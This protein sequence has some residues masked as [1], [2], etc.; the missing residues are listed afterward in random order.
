MQQVF[1]TGG[2]GFVG[3]TLLA[4]LG[5]RG[6]PA[7]ALARSD[8]PANAVAALGAEVARGDLDD[9]AAMTAGMKGCDVVVHAAAHVK[10]HGTRDEFFRGNVTGTENALAAARAA[11]VTRFVH[12]GTEAVLADGR[13]IIR[14]D[15]DTPLPAEPA[16]L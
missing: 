1:V 3:R 2:S 4:E 7:R 12:V 6:I 9:V 8:A 10:E 15:E 5:R 16:G 14:A 11:G 13:P